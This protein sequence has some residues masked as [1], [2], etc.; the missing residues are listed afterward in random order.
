M[1]SSHY[2]LLPGSGANAPSLSLLS[3]GLALLLSRLT[4]LLGPDRL[5]ASLGA[6]SFSL[7]LHL[8]QQVG[9]IVQCN[10]QIGMVWSKC[11]L[12]QCQ[13]TLVERCSFRV[14]ALGFVHHCQVV[15]RRGH[16]RMVW[17]NGLLKELQHILVE[18]PSLS[19]F[20]LGVVQYR[21]GVQRRGQARVFGASLFYVLERCQIKH[22]RIGFLTVLVRLGPFSHV[23]FPARVLGPDLRRVHRHTPHDKKADQPQ[24][25]R[26]SRLRSH[27]MGFPLPSGSA[28]WHPVLSVASLP[29][30]VALLSLLQHM[31]I[32]C[33]PSY[34]YRRGFLIAKLLFK[35][36]RHV[37]QHSV[38]SRQ[39]HRQGSHFSQIGLGDHSPRKGVVSCPRPP[40]RYDLHHIR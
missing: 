18:W 2:G 32:L 12:H 29:E 10:S 37:T 38:T 30:H 26:K 24:E 8:T 20:S 16:G 36:T 14:L 4:L 15:Q 3:D 28:S 34:E 19:V 1:R 11:A 39:G 6:F 21:Q 7:A 23:M 25:N 5:G 27:E 31:R 33:L 9:V 40:V 35:T 22:F 17:T 13:G